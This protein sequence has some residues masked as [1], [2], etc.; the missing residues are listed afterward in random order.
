VSR[1]AVDDAPPCIHPDAATVVEE[2]AK[3]LASA[4]TRDFAP[5]SEMPSK[6]AAAC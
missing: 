5:D 1:L 6:S 3:L 4:L 2:S